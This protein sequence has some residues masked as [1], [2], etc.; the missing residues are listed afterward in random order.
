M[1]IV[2]IHGGL[3]NQICE[4][5]FL[6]F[7]KEIL[8]TK[9]PEALVK[10][11]LTWYDRN[12]RVHQGYE[13]KRVFDLDLPTA[14]Y[15]E[16]AK[17]HEYYPHYHSFMPLRVISRMLARIRNAHHTPSGGYIYDFDEYCYSYNPV[18]EELDKTKDWYIEGCFC[19]DAYFSRISDIVLKELKFV[20]LNDS[21]DIELMDKINTQDAVA[22]HVRRG[23]YN[24]TVFDVVGVDY[25]RK[26][27]EYI[28]EKVKD[29][30]FYV[31]SDDV[32][33]VESNFTFLEDYKII[34]HSGR[35]SFRDMQFISACK[36]KITANSTF[37][38]CA[39]LLGE[40]TGGIII[41]PSKYKADEDISMARAGWITI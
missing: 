15:K 26:A 2:R 4:Y 32:E 28:K 41:S 19:S 13:L 6:R 14:S 12:S 31:F 16:I 36:H 24:G 21:K 40:K 11:D 20:P 23:D 22:I 27:A 17:V 9:D 1:Y 39:A 38:Y 7:F 30:V 5:I 25:Y 10:A 33:Y 29:P 8:K 35:E 3:G 34:H 18:Y 37:S